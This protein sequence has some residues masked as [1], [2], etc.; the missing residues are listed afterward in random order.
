MS[1]AMH[2]G[3]GI[4]SNVGDR[5]AHIRAA[6]AWLNHISLKPIRS[7][8]IYE[9]LPI[10]CPPGSPPFL[11]AACEITYQDDLVALLAKMKEFEKE[12]GRIPSLILNS[13]RPMDLDML[14]ADSLVLSTPD[15][16]L[17]HPRMIERRFVMQPLADIHPNLVL[18]GATKTVVQIMNS[19]S[20]ENIR[21]FSK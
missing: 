17:P 14:Y 13:P 16:V 15:L 8:F 3:I 9:S 1:K 21:L 4:G 10:G 19:L 2:I 11:N 6:F 20:E 7:S 18:P 12:R 5:L